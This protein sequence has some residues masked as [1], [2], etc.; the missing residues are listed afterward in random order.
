MHV[1]HPAIG[2]GANRATAPGHALIASP[3]RG[4]TPD[5]RVVGTASA[6]MPSSAASARA[7]SGGRM[8]ATGGGA[9]AIGRWSMGRGPAGGGPVRCPAS[10][11]PVRCPASAWPV[12]CAAPG[13]S[14][15]LSGRLRGRLRSWCCWLLCFCG[16]ACQAACTQQSG[17]NHSCRNTSYG[18]A[19]NLHGH[20][21]LIPVPGPRSI[22]ET[23]TLYST[24]LTFPLVKVTFMSG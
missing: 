22:H 11:W 15:R 12:R 5:R 18:F 6:G 14:S 21:V 20:L 24:L 19:K 4:A 1:A 2:P 7:P 23:R 17:K 9:W 16:R 8:F 3:G 13:A 10:A